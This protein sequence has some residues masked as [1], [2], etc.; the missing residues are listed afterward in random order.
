MLG[1]YGLDDVRHE[2]TSKKVASE[3][4]GL[5]TV[6]TG[7]SPQLDPRRVLEHGPLKNVLPK[8]RGLGRTAR[9]PLVFILFY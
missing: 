6:F 9:E 1:R 5:K 7:P 8:A 4:I 2:L 3:G